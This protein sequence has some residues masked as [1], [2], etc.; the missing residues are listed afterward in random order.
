MSSGDAVTEASHVGSTGT[1]SIAVPG[2]SRASRWGGRSCGA[3]LTPWPRGPTSVHVP[4]G[5]TRSLRRLPGKRPC[6]K[7]R[8]AKQRFERRPITAAA[9]DL[10]AVLEEN[11][12]VAIEQWL[13]FANPVDGDDRRA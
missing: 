9:V 13:D 3:Q 11:D 2:A 4:G 5:G 1:L 7:Q 12:E 10:H 6:R 8:S